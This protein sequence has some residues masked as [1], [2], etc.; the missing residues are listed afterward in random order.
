MITTASEQILSVTAVT[1]ARLD[2]DLTVAERV[3][4]IRAAGDR[5]LGILVT[6]QRADSYT[7][8]LSPEVPYGLTQERAL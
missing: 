6:R 3:L 7:V 1:K 4:R 5:T 2:R 8:A